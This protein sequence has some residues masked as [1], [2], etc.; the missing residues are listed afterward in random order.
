MRAG[1]PTVLSRWSSARTAEEVMASAD[2]MS[3]MH[4]RIIYLPAVSDVAGGT[5]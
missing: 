1:M 3:V 5:P 2:N 4:F